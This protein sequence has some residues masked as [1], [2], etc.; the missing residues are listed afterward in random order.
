[1]DERL[2]SFAPPLGPGFGPELLLQVPP[3]GGRRQAVEEALR[4]A[5]RGGRLRAGTRL[6]S[7]REL[8]SQ[9][10]LARGTV[11]AAY[12]QLVAEGWL[13]SRSGS[14]TRVAAGASS[15]PAAAPVR[16]APSAAPSHDLRPGRT[17]GGAFP[18]DAWARAMRHVLREA[19]AD[20]FGRG[21]ARGRLE[22]RTTLAAY[23]G[24]VRG[25]RVDP[26]HV[27]VC[28]GFTQALGLLTEV[29]AELG[30][31]RA[32]MENP[33]VGNHVR[34]VASRLDVA[35]IAVD[36]EGMSCAELAAS[37]AGVAVCTP[38]HQFPL[39]M[40]MAPARRAGLLAWAEEN[41][42]WIVEDDYD[43]EFRYDRKPVGALQ[44]RRPSRVVYA[45]SASKSLG[46]AVRLGWIAC[47]PALL[48]PLVE[49]KRRAQPTS[50]LEQLALA[51][52]ID[53]G[54]YDRHLRGVRRAYRRRRDLLAEAVRSRLPRTRVLGI[55]AGLHAILRLPSGVPD[56]AAVLA[57][58]RSAS[59]DVHALGA[60]LRAPLD[61]ERR[62]PSLVVGYGT[63][64]ARGYRP[65]IDALVGRLRELG[66]A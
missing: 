51:R 38:A 43:G 54:G 19:P 65:A 48:E 52:L 3:R 58:L 10:G 44:A 32:A 61:H 30:V 36:A 15:P 26:S 64:P 12:E 60:Y 8:A 14:G 39:G 27:L 24:R 18:R 40:S 57:A 13:T 66:A 33:A 41:L 35:D 21:D 50:P 22:L 55:E 45:G 23:L 20:A 1:M 25:V 56:E 62:P 16:A 6:P 37:G 46:P 5:I 2:D 7:S 53:S 63:P 17:D 11:A 9:L 29:F 4:V 31:G 59:V 28:S 47:P 34:V 42:G 49:A